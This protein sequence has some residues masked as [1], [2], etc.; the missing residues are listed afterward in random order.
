MTSIFLT[1]GIEK[2]K[3]KASARSALNGRIMRGRCIKIWNSTSRRG[4]IPQIKKRLACFKN[5][6]SRA[7]CRS[8]EIEFELRVRSLEKFSVHKN[9]KI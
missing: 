4:E 8:T 9:V 3:K 7:P 1:R 5:G 2:Q 6:F